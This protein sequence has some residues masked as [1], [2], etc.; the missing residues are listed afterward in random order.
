ME[1]MGR[2]RLEG[3]SGEGKRVREGVCFVLC[4]R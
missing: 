1:G 3:R 4:M 2:C